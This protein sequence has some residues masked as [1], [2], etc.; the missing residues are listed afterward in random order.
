[1]TKT[2][3]VPA[4]TDLLVGEHEQQG[5]LQFIFTQHS[6]NYIAGEDGNVSFRRDFGQHHRLIPTFLSCLR[7]SVPVVRVDYEDDTL[8]V[9]EV[10]KEI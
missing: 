9:L 6:L 1:M 5:I 2:R 4:D 3:E 7:D 10:C 8:G